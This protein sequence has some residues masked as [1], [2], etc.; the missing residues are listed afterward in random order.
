MDEYGWEIETL[1]LDGWQMMTKYRIVI[2]HQEVWTSRVWCLVFFSMFG[3]C[4]FAYM[5][6]CLLFVLQWSDESDGAGSF[7][8]GGWSLCGMWVTCLG[9][10]WFC[11]FVRV[12]KW[13]WREAI[14]RRRKWGAIVI[15]RKRAK[16]FC[17]NWWNCIVLIWLCFEWFAK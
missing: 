1:I 7:P 6:L 15:T 12:G 8:H 10:G 9:V 3:C 16:F 4:L 5:L 2:H 17:S 11:G 13:C 14:R